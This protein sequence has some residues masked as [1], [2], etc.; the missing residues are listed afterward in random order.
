MTK[1]L[2]TGVF[3]VLHPGHL[4][5]LQEARKLGDELVVIVASD[6]IAR[7]T[8]KGF[9]LP[10]E[11]RAK[12][13]GSLKMVDKVFIGDEKDTLSLLPVIQPDI[14]ALGYDQRVD[15]ERLQSTLAARGV[16]ARVFRIKGREEGDFMSA[17]G[18]LR[19]VCEVFSINQPKSDQA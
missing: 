17:S 13:I 16:N 10:Q 12:V 6:R 11:Q 9:I 4:L 18:I 8:K 14:I 3:N 19:K 2:A 5:F 15:E 7:R 1:V